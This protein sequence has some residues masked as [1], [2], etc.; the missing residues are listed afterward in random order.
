MNTF[1]RESA[2]R[3]AVTT[4]KLMHPR[5]KESDYADH[6]WGEPLL[7]TTTDGDKFDVEM[8]KLQ[9]TSAGLFATK[10]HAYNA[11][12]GIYFESSPRFWAWDSVSQPTDA[13]V[14][15]TRAAIRLVL[16]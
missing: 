6:D 11:E 13:E 9:V 4:A 16:D 5:L 12:D 1:D 7:I 10:S 2:Y 3:H 15:L 8:Q 14:E